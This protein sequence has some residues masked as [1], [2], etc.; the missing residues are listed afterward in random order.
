VVG[1]ATEEPVRSCE[2]VKRKESKTVWI[3]VPFAW[4]SVR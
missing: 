1:L 3:S 2:V 4:R